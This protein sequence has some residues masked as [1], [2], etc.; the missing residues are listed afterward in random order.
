[1]KEKQFLNKKLTCI[2]TGY[3]AKIV[4]HY[5]LHEVSYVKINIMMQFEN[6]DFHVLKTCRTD[7]IESQF[8]YS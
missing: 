5:E 4:N 3:K 8:N 2:K 7:E 1:M 6:S